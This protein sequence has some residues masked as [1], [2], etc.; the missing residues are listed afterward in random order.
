VLRALGRPRG[1]ADIVP[2]ARAGDG[3]RVG[4]VGI[5]VVA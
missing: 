5:T 3:V 4:D 1:Y 2:G